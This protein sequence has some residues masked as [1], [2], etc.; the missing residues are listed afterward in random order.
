[1]DTN[2]VA[3]IFLGS[4]LAF[5]AQMT[6]Q[7]LGEWYKNRG[8]KKNFILF[9]KVQIKSIIKS[10][11]KLSSLYESNSYFNK[12][13]ANRINEDYKRLSDSLK[14]S[15]YLSYSDTRE[16]LAYTLTDLSGLLDAVYG[17]EDLSN[18][19]DAELNELKKANPNLKKQDK[20]EFDQNFKTPKEIEEIENFNYKFFEKKRIETLITITDLIK[21]LDDLEN[22]IK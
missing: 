13:V 21:R 16:R 20:K 22:L 7:I 2:N 11:Q 5:L 9:T 18:Q 4:I 19:K 17:I 6:V 14:D 15:S 1:M 12:T 3:F 8:Y 10:L